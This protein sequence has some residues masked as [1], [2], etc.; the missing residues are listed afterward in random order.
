MVVK[1][2]ER[3]RYGNPGP[4]ALKSAPL[5]AIFPLSMVSTVPA[6]GTTV[7][8]PDLVDRTIALER[9][10]LKRAT[11]VITGGLVERF[12]AFEDVTVDSVSGNHDLV[13]RSD[14]LNEIGVWRS[15]PGGSPGAV[16]GRPTLAVLRSRPHVPGAQPPGPP[17]DPPSCPCCR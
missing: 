16:W 7:L 1:S 5:S 4:A 2:P 14:P 11:P 6:P 3:L 13:V 8:V 15:P 10:G 12:N 9:E 17:H